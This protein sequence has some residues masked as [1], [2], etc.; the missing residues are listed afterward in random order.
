MRYDLICL[1]NWFLSWSMEYWLWWGDCL[2]RARDGWS[3]IDWGGPDNIVHSVNREGH[4][5]VI[6]GTIILVPHQHMS[7]TYLTLCWIWMIAEWYYMMTSSNGNIFHVAGHLCGEFTGIIAVW[8]S[9]YIICSIEYGFPHG[10][11]HVANM[12]P[13]WVLSAPGGP[14]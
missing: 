2:C 7:L 11:V 9:T 8:Y 3:G 1:V 4:L 12:G 14:H 5:A 6:A 13:T 10:K